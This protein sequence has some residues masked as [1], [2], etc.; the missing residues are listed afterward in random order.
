M[1]MGATLIKLSGSQNKNQKD[2]KAGGGNLLGRNRR[3]EGVG[4]E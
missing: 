3:S 4:G 1:L 2:M